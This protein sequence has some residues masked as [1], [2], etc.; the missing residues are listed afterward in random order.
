MAYL[1]P[2]PIVGDPTASNPSPSSTSPWCKIV[3]QVPPYESFSNVDALLAYHFNAPS[4]LIRA[5]YVVWWE[6]FCI[7]SQSNALWI[8]MLEKSAALAAIIM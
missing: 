4:G 3:S 7:E 1:V 2:R 5:L 8:F 6:D